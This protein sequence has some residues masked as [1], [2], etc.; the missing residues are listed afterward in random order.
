LAGEQDARAAGDDRGGGERVAGHVQERP[1]ACSRRGPRPTSSAAITPFIST[2][3]A[4]TI[5]IS[6]LHGDRRERRW[7][8]SIAIQSE[9]TMS[10]AALMKAAST[11]ARW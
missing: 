10:V 1:S 4:A 2:P 6:G 7:T 11:P 9:M 8:A 5:I 3:A